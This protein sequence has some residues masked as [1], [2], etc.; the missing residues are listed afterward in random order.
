MIILAVSYLLAFCDSD[1]KEEL[2]QLLEVVDVTK[3]SS[4]KYLSSIFKSLGRL[5]LENFTEKFILALK[6]SGI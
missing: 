2:P 4:D 1:R 5:Q 6:N 3:I